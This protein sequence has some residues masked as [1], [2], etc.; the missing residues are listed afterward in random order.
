MPADPTDIRAL[1]DL[2]AT[3]EDPEAA[4]RALTDL[5]AELDRLECEHVQRALG[6]GATWS[7]IAAALGVSKQAA[8][9]RHRHR[10][11][12]EPGGKK[13]RISEDAR[14]AIA[15]GREEARRAGA[16]V[17][18]PEHLLLGVLAMDATRA[19][20]ALEGLGAT[21]DRIRA[22]V[23]QANST[24]RGAT[25]GLSPEA[26]RALEL[27]LGKATGQDRQGIDV[28]GLLL[29]LLE[30]NRGPAARAL[31]AAGVSPEALRSLIV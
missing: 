1:A 3:G 24:P 16:A 8:H 10:K 29:A 20:R 28:E 12:G 25:Q 11:T 15:Y 5:R 27:S 30:D 13:V 18:G 9:K 6:S 7:R 17:I 23:L 21:P 31:E 19:S 22:A 26:K 4:L 2:A 14:R